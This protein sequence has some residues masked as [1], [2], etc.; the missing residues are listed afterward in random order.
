MAITISYAF[1]CCDPV[2][3]TNSLAD[4][5]AANSGDNSSLR[6]GWLD[7]FKPQKKR[8]HLRAAEYSANVL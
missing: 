8:I 4:L 1:F 3:V 5:V 2:Y 7:Q 6:L